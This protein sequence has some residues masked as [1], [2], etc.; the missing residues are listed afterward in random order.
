MILSEILIAERVAVANEAEGAVGDAAAALNRL[1]QLLA[2][3]QAAVSADM[4]REVLA[5]REKI[6]STGVGGG[7][8]LGPVRAWVPGQRESPS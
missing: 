4:I 3:G 2:V 7:A 6:Q 8:A 1:A 5:E